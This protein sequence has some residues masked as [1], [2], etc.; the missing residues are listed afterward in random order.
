MTE[1]E[2]RGNYPPHKVN[3]QCEFDDFMNRLNTEQTIINHPWIDAKKEI[4]KKKAL[5]KVQFA[6]LQASMSA[7]RAEW[8]DID[9]K[10]K[11]FNRICHDIKHEMIEL[12]PKGLKNEPTP[13]K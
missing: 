3:S 1:K 2:I 13:D 11:E 12:N 7:L 8:L 10:Q 5:I 4:E 6:S 9:M